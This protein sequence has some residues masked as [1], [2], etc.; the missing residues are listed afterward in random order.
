MPG[1]LAAAAG[2]TGRP[3]L[4]QDIAAPTAPGAEGLRLKPKAEAG[5]ALPG[6]ALSA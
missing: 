4:A 2:A 5:V 3:W 1:W 6:G